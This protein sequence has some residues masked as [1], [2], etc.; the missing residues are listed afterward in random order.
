LSSKIK[1]SLI[2]ISWK[3]FHGKLQILRV[4]PNNIKI[5]SIFALFLRKA[6]YYFPQGKDEKEKWEY[7]AFCVSLHRYPW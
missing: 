5:K 6:S 2:F 7:S 3:N 1:Q 4:T